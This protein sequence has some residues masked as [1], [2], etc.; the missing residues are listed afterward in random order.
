MMHDMANAQGWRTAIES[1]VV[2]RKALDH[3]I[4]TAQINEVDALEE[5]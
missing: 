1:E 3:L 5:A 2:D 4:E